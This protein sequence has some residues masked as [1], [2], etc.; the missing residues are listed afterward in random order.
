MKHAFAASAGLFLFT[1]AALATGTPG[2][3][4]FGE[5]DRLASYGAFDESVAH[6][7]KAEKLFEEAKNSAGQ[8]EAEIHLAAAYHALGQTN[9]AIE[10]L[11]RVEAA[12][13]EKADVKHVAA[14]KVAL[15]AIYI[16]STPPMQ[17]NMDHGA[18]SEG[19]AEANLKEG[20]K[21]ARSVRDSHLE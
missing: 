2:A 18:M 15:G 10:I 16:L 7:K 20:L 6:W 17:M 4:E 9:L 11:R 3:S 5:A 21:L 1:T 8:V 12:A 14:A 19:D 13:A